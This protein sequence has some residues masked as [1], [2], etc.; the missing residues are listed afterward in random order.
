M[1]KR[2]R[3]SRERSCRR[4]QRLHVTLHISGGGGGSK[5]GLPPLF[6]NGVPVAPHCGRRYCRTVVTSVVTKREGNRSQ[7][8]HYLELKK[9]PC[10]VLIAGRLS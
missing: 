9:C 5:V 4:R 3:S 1:G 10:I 6:I 8:V 7:F 2:G